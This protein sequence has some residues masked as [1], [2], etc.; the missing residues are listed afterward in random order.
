MIKHL[1]S[2]KW[3]LQQQHQ[4]W[5]DLKTHVS[6]YRNRN[7]IYFVSFPKSGRTWVR[8]FLNY[9]FFLLNPLSVTSRNDMRYYQTIPDIQ[10]HHGHYNYLNAGKIRK[11]IDAF[12]S[13]QV[14]FMFRD[15]RDIFVSYYF[16]LTKRSEPAKRVYKK[17]GLPSIDWTAVSMGEVL[18]NPYFGIQWIVQFLN[19]WYDALPDF[20]RSHLLQYERIK[21]DP[22]TEFS[23][24]LQFILPDP[25]NP[26]ALEK[27]VEE[28]RF[29]KMKENEKNR[30]HA[31][32]ELS[33]DNARDED[34]FKVR[35]GKIGGYKD[36]LTPDEID[37][38]ETAITQL[39]PVLRK[40]YKG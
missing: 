10:Y 5:I 29:N 12:S 21:T 31:E 16:Q 4:R 15:P 37:Y 40:I 3:Q 20:K 23:R 36:Y 39:H 13:K 28:T 6:C 11:A 1:N 17:S 33:S 24:L 7:N 38:M 34:S 2:V 26:F 18:V 14:I 25:V 19:L 32:Y 35:R 22:H 27:A 30:L 8:M 9:Y